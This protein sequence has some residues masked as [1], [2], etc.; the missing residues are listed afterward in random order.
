MLPAVVATTARGATTVVGQ[1]AR[2]GTG[3]A[4]SQAQKVVDIPM[5]TNQAS[6][7]SKQVLATTKVQDP[8]FFSELWGKVK[9]QFSIG[10]TQDLNASNANGVA[11]YLLNYAP[12]V[13]AF[14]LIDGL[15]SAGLNDPAYLASISQLAR[16]GI[17]DAI[18]EDL[19]AVDGI[20]DGKLGAK[21]IA[22]L[23]DL[24]SMAGAR[25][26]CNSV[27]QLMEIIVFIRRI[28]MAELA[29]VCEYAAATRQTRI[30]QMRVDF[31]EAELD[32]KSFLARLKGLRNG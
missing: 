2:S 9:N 15:R 17:A 10:S 16:S 8:G 29:A 25:L 18:D 6:Q 28:G 24:I 27:T 11:D 14:H 30:G 12:R 22:V 26:N 31:R 7:F 13:M 4:L 32:E 1:A 19:R 3:Q 23:T 21:E 5:T 20:F